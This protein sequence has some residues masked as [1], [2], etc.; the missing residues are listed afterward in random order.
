[1]A[2][3]TVVVTDDRYGSYLEEEAVLGEIGARLEVKNLGSAEE[4]VEVLS[5]A[6]AVLVNLFPMSAKVISRLDRVKVISRYGVGFDNV[7]VEAATRKGIWVARVPDYCQE[8]ASDQTI[9]LLLGCI[10]KIAYKDRKIR[11]G[12][13]DLHK[14]QPT[15]R[16]AGKTLGII[17]YG[18]VGKRLHAKMAAFGLGSILVCDPLEDQEG[19]RK[20]GATPVDLERLLRESDYVSLHVPLTPETRAMIGAREL[21]MMK[22]TAF[23]INTSRG[24]VVDEGALAG[25]LESG[26]IAGA[27][28]DVFQK[29]PLPE[30]S[31][32]KGLDTV[33]LSDHASWYSVES[34]KE[35]KTKAARNVARVLEGGEPVYSVNSILDARREKTCTR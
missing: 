29:E 24:P 26:R 34:E 6:D 32:L 10:R 3:F 19:I 15:S 22:A 7:D 25:A 14:H 12:A 30:D 31:P 2:K 1:M 11:E 4:A 18:R 33:I 23:L 8:E 28:L 5:G 13:W 16:I 20:S 17:G 35:L 27:G 21:G 9:A